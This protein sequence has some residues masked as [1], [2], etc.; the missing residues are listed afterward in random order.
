MRG[1]RHVP[2]VAAA[3]LALA[4]A[5]PAGAAAEPPTSFGITRI[6]S[7]NLISSVLIAPKTVDMRGGWTDDSMPCTTWRTLRVQMLVQYTPASGAAKIVRRKREA[8]V[9]NCAEGGP[10]LGR[11]LRATRLGLACPDGT[12]KPGRYDF[13]TN[14]RHLA[15]KV[16]AIATLGWFNDDPC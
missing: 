4:A 15:R 7:F 10:N 2:I 5:A 14:T 12:W 1:L 6:G 13:V 11:T 3:V 8:P 16:N 9:Q